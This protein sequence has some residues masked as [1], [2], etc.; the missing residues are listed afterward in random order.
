MKHFF[1]P[2]LSAAAV[3]LVV[4]AGCASQNTTK[5]VDREAQVAINSSFRDEGIAKVDRLK[6]DDMQA[7]CSSAKPP[8][9]A[10]QDKIMAEARASVQ[11]PAGGRYFGDWK[12]GEKLAQ[13]GRGL[14]WTDP[15]LATRD[16]GG[17][18]Y[19]CHQLSKAE[20]SYGT[21]GPSLYHYGR[22]RGVTDLAAPTAQPIIEITWVRLYNAKSF[23]ACSTMPRFGYH[24]MLDT[25]QMADL[26]SLLLDPKSPVNQ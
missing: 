16:N 8:S 14:T 5:D 19:N 4:V 11:W 26:M 7:A 24:G 3:V 6:Q 23:N 17:N 2:L 22:N 20:L 10:E 1:K 13:S 9:Q 12:A 18:C 21:I 25:A 15:S